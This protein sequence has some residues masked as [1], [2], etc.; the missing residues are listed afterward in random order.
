VPKTVLRSRIAGSGQPLS[1]MH[2]NHASMGANLGH[3]TYAPSD[4]PPEKIAANLSSIRVDD[5]WPM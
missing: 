4:L 2:P 3:T 5:S 1:N